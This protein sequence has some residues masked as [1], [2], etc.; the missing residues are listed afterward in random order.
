M[1]VKKIEYRNEQER[2]DLEKE[3]DDYSLAIAKY[4]NYKNV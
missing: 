2:I 4:N 3:I 1:N